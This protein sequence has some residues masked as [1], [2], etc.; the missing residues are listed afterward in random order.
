MKAK[1][2]EKLLAPV[3][4]NAAVGAKL[5]KRLEALVDEMNRSVTHWIEAQ[6]RKAPPEIAQDDAN[7][8]DL[9]QRTMEK[10]S[11]RWLERFDE[12]AIEMSEYFA[13]GAQHRSDARLRSI[14]RKAGIT[15]RFKPTKAQ[16]DIMAATVNEAV[17]LIKSIPQKYLTNV[18]GL[19]MRSVQ[20]GRDLGK[21]S[22]DLQKQY[23]IAKRRA[24]TIA[25][26]QNNKATAAMNRARQVE[27]G[28]T[29]A[30]WVHSA[31]GKHPRPSH[32][33]A[34][35]EKVRYDVT[36]GWYDPSVGEFILPGTLPNC[37]CTSR[38]VIRGFI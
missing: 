29:E 1:P 25:R 34:S 12:A 5:R 24:A 35:R 32:V 9:M 17:G 11:K 7:P 31:A 26:D 22:E 10:L 6:Y 33:K 14:L 19:V 37:R 21:L 2:D 18:Q 27:L 38:S 3:R 30:V 28:I 15:V 8:A 20:T 16:Q 36:K 23:G 13:R 4:A